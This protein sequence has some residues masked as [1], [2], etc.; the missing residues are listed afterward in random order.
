[1][2]PTQQN[3]LG[4][5]CLTAGAVYALVWD[6]GQ[7]V[8]A[9]LLSVGLL[10]LDRRQPTGRLGRLGLIV[11]IIA[12]NVDAVLA[13]LTLF[14]PAAPAEIGTTPY[15]MLGLGLAVGMVV[16]GI[17]TMRARRFRG[18]ELLILGPVLIPIIG[19]W[20]AKIGFLGFGALAYF[21]FTAQPVET[22]E[23]ALAEN[24]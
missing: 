12:L 21:L 19:V 10:M 15:L 6:V 16:Y 24:R 13:L 4:A 17:A 1:V 2:T 5:V 7:F 18:G 23:P 22:E 9:V 11:L 14:D 8:P 3:Q 20:G